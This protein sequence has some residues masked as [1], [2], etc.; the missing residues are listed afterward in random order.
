MPKMD[1][2]LEA[3]ENLGKAYDA[4]PLGVHNTMT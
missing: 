2:W 1:D 4:D 3:L